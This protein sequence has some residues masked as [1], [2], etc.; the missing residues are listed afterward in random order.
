[1]QTV[2]PIIIPSPISGSP[3]RPRIKET[4]RDGKIYTEAYWYCPDS[5]QFIKKGLISVTDPKDVE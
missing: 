3:V 2:R 4:V 1:M 5:G